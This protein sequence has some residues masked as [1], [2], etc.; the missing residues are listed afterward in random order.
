MHFMNPR[1]EDAL[2]AAKSP[3]GNREV[4]GCSQ[5]QIVSISRFGCT[6]V[7]EGMANQAGGLPE[8]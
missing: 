3:R 5:F 2:Q 6:D 8:P 4:G 1:L 7:M